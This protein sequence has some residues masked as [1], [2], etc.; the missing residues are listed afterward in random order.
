MLDA[1]SWKLTPLNAFRT[2][3]SDASTTGGATR[4]GVRAAAPPG[5]WTRTAR[6][7]PPLGSVLSGRRGQ[8]GAAAARI[9]R[10]AASRAAGGIGITEREGS[11]VR[12]GAC[13]WPASAAAGG[14]GCACV[15]LPLK[16]AAAP[17][18]PAGRGGGVIDRF[19]S[20]PIGLYLQYA[21]RFRK[22]SL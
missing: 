9:M 17:A 3:S 6:M 2:S 10:R 16:A 11:F 5:V 19:I 7:L 8:H 22:Y 15:K 13:L 4:S 21:I 20:V 1:L 18:P 14:R 12:G